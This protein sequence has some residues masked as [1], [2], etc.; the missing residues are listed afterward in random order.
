MI[1][2]QLKL[3]NQNI[4]QQGMQYQLNHY[5]QFDPHDDPHTEPKNFLFQFPTH[6]NN[7]VFL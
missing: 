2:D 6:E 1:L 4:T 7:I 5:L 3:Y